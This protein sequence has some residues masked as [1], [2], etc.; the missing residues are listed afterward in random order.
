MR[1]LALDVSVTGCSVRVWNSETS[2]SKDQRV[3]T[4]RGQAEMLIPMI[5]AVV[6]ES[7]MTLQDLDCI[8]VTVGPGSFT[9][10]R[11]GLSTAR[12]LGL[13]LDI[14]VMG[15][16]S[17]SA[18]ARSVPDSADA[19]IL[20]DTKRGD[21]YGQIGA[22][23]E[24][25]IWSEDEVQAFSGRVVNGVVPD[26]LVIARMACEM[27]RAASCEGYDIAKAPA[28]VYVRGAEVSLPKS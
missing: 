22:S 28:P 24:P 14:P 19:L 3:E 16:S 2:E 4:E 1:V 27:L 6:Q 17:L 21:Y 15:V 8:G 25:R 12:S 7:G 9:G 10:V 5:E 23:G 26:S 20:I 18:I 11:I 13:A